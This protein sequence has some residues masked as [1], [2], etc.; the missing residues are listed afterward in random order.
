[1]A[2]DLLGL[3]PA[4]SGR[5]A[6]A[7]GWAYGHRGGNPAQRPILTEHPSDQAGP[8]TEIASRLDPEVA[9]TNQR[10]IA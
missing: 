6:L 3:F 2:G 7:S 5:I 4:R 8:L 9:A 10:T 1:M